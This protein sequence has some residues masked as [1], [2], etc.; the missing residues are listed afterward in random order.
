[1]ITH[2]WQSGDTIEILFDMP[3]R[4]LHTHPLVRDTAGKAALARGP[5][6]YCFESI[7][8]GD[9][10]V[11]TLNTSAEISVLPYDASLLGGVVPIQAGRLRAIPY[12][13]WSNRGENAMRVFLPEISYK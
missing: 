7:D 11:C 2:E 8:N 9:L 3:P 6:V 1:M 5:F 12:Y 13:A 4:L 10:S